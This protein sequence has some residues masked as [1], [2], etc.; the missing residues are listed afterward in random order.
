MASVIVF[1]PTGNIGSV[2]ARTAAEHGAKVALAMRDTN[3][4]IP[5][6]SKE[7]EQAGSFT[8]VQADLRK[9]ETVAEAVK[10]S[11]AKRAFIYLAHGTP[12]HM[13]STLEAM[14]AA[15]VDFVV[16]LSSFTIHRDK[17]LRDIPPSDIIDYMHAQVEANL[18]DVFGSEHYVAVR[19]G[20]FATNLLRDKKGIAAGEVPLFA[21]QSQQDCITPGDMGRVSGKI[22]V[23]GPKNGQQKVYLYG[24]QVMS[25]RE[26]IGEIGKALGKEIKITDLNAEEGRNH[27]MQ[28]GFP[29]AFVDYFIRKL[30]ESTG[31]EWSAIFPL[32]EEGVE[33]VKLYTGRPSTTFQEWVGANKEL[34]DA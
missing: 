1:G 21:G 5:G 10:T 24:P 33:N 6:L 11:G 9:P 27:F 25:H 15:G 30:G 8:R 34:F 29:P 18:D 23:E 26:T 22:L 20:A 16:F 32:Y 7:K 4:A 28:L 13:K 14:K 31:L 3:K 2:A 12:D 17:P 19:P